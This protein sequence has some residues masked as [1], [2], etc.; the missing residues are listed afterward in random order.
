VAGEEPITRGSC[1]GRFEIL[2]TWGVVVR[3]ELTNSC[4]GKTQGSF[5]VGVTPGKKISSGT[6]KGT[7]YRCPFSV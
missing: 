3:G 2:G 7:L 1:Q 6:E 5:T 4:L